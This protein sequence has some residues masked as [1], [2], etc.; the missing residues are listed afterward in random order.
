MKSKGSKLAVLPPMPREE[1]FFFSIAFCWWICLW[2]LC[3]PSYPAANAFLFA[4]LIFWETKDLPVQSERPS[5]P[6]P[7]FLS[8]CVNYGSCAL[9]LHYQ[10]P[11]VHPASHRAHEQQQ[12]SVRFPPSPISQGHW[13]S[14]IVNDHRRITC[15]NYSA[16]FT[17]N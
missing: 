16:I 4:C 1:G 17:T 15:C 9:G 6:P 14:H 11:Q 3:W 10:D 13:L 12:H 7:L 2:I 5:Y 8:P